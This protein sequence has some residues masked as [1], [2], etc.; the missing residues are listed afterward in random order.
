MLTYISS[1]ISYGTSSFVLMKITEIEA[2]LEL[3][4]NLHFQFYEAYLF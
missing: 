3:N 4:K 2:K 1:I